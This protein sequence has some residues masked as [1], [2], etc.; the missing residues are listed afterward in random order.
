[1][2]AEQSYFRKMARGGALA[3][4]GKVTTYPLG[5]LL[6]IVL[7]R[8]LAPAELGGYFLAMSLILVTATLIQFGTGPVVVKFVSGA[9]TTKDSG[10]A[11]QVLNYGFVWML[12]TS[13]LALIAY[14][15]PFGS[16]LLSMLRDSDVLHGTLT[17]IALLA[18]AYAAIS[19]ICEVLRSFSELGIASLFAEQ[20]M[21]RLLLLIALTV[22]WLSDFEIDLYT[23]FILMAAASAVT[24]FLGLAFVFANYRKLTRSADQPADPAALIRQ[25]PPFFFMRLNFWLMDTA[26]VWVLGMFHASE[27]VALY[28]V[29]NMLALI[30]LAPWTV[31]NTSLGPAIVKLHTE[32]RPT[33]LQT[34][35]STVAGIATILA[36]GVALLLIVF[37]QQLLSIVFSD[38]LSPAYTTMIILAVGRA[39]S[40]FFGAPALLLSMT[41]HQVVVF[42]TLL[43]TSICSFVGY[44]SAAKF[45]SIEWVAVAG[46]I[47]TIT[48]ALL[49]VYLARRHLKI[50]TISKFRSSEWGTIARQVFGRN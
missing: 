50:S 15:T 32:N 10:R 37:G 11:R 28:G 31:T 8:V 43:V 33:T 35:L 40:V 20:L 36:A 2:N 1:M 38:A 48:Q 3:V 49:L 42:R 46:S 18:V 19:F 13:A 44:F 6:A 26:P 4:A 17:W 25:T 34:M 39:I 9:L 45:G 16:W 47:A 14:H 30:V 21:Q 27:D 5:F 41:N 29:G 22:L 24:V 12:A 7:A 23:I